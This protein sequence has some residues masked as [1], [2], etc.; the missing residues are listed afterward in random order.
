MNEDELWE[1][2]MVLWQQP[3]HR[4]PTVV[5]IHYYMDADG[6]MVQ[7][8]NSLPGKGFKWVKAGE[9]KPLVVKEVKHVRT[10]V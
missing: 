4:N 6:V 10:S 7:K 5:T 1:G 2:R 8:T 9:L 3:G